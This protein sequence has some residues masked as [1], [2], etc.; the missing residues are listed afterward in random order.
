MPIDDGGRR[1]QLRSER[2]PLDFLLVVIE[3]S[4]YVR[5]VEVVKFLVE[6]L[7]DENYFCCASCEDARSPDCSRYVLFEVI[8]RQIFQDELLE[9]EVH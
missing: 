1:R 9:P 5:V 2:L 8:R 3:H 7:L 4:L 6:T